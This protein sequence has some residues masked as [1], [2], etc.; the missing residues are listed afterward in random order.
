MLLGGLAAIAPAQETRVVGWGD[1]LTFG[2]YDF[3]NGSSPSACYSAPSQNPL[4]TCGHVGRLDQRLNA[5][6]PSWEIEVLN[7]GREGEDTMEAL[8][9]IGDP[10]AGCAP[11]PAINR[12]KYWQ[13]TGWLQPHDLFVLMEGTNDITVGISRES[14][15][16]NLETLGTRA[17]AFGLDVV[18]ATLIPRHPD[19][20]IDPSNVQNQQR[21]SDIAGLAASHGWPLVDTYA[22]LDAIQQSGGAL[23]NIYYQNWS[24]VC[25]GGVPGGG[26]DPVGHVNDRGYDKISFEAQ[27]LY[28]LTF[29][30]NVKLALPPRLDFA[31][32]APPIETGTPASF[33]VTLFDLATTAS[34][35]WSFGDGTPPVTVVPAGSPSGVEHVYLVPGPYTVT[36]TALHANGG[37]RQ[38]SAGITVTGVDLTL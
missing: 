20:C 8:S 13:C 26:G 2:S 38:R 34:V 28:P 36:V 35:R 3:P 22:R 6:I 9:R 14:T 12:L 31:P 17:E 25:P 19:A 23:F 33:E 15:E 21:N 10:G 32:P 29:E 7:L 30:A 27:A 11:L 5:E 16:F 37:D 18:I 1:S 24:E 4:E